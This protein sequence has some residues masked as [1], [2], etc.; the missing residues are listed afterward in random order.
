[1][2]KETTKEKRC[3]NCFVC[4]ANTELCPLNDNYRELSLDEWLKRLE[5]IKKK[6]KE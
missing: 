6:D 2:K 4:V 1:L 3:A 5:G